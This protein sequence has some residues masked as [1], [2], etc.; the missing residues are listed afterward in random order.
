VAQLYPWALGSF[1]VAS[2]DS[3]S[4]GGGILTRLYTNTK[5]NLDSFC[6]KHLGTDRTENTVSNISSVDTSCGYRSD[7]VDNTIPLLLFYGRYLPTAV[8]SASF[9]LCLT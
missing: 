2:Y 7:R 1:L 5:L 9:R 4:Y 8:V 3:Q 6:L